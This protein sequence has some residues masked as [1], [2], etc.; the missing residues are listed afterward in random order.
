MSLN[1]AEQFTFSV[2][3]QVQTQAIMQKSDTFGSKLHTLCQICKN[4]KM[5]NDTLH[6][7]L[8]SLCQN[9][10]GVAI[11]RIFMQ[12]ALTRPQNL[13]ETD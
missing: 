12:V 11:L 5:K 6:S 8:Y 7:K 1:P 10:Y 13:V 2:N 4:R 3:P 9:R